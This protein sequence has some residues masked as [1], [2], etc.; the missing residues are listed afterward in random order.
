MLH[1]AEMPLKFWAEA[2]NTAVY[3]RNRSPTTALDGITPYECFHGE[4]PDVS[5][6]RVFG[7]KAFV[8]VPKERRSKLEGKSV[9]CIFVGYPSTSKGFKFYDIENDKMVIS[10]DAK[11]LENDFLH[12]DSKNSQNLPELS[13]VLIEE[14]HDVQNEELKNKVATRKSTRKRTIPE[15][16]GTITS[17]CWENE[18][19][20]CS[21]AIWIVLN[22]VVYMK[23]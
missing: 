23:Y 15:R 12:N 10:R 2:L 16:F 9:N 13:I 7:C 18:D 3:L 21:L 14:V 11:F 22:Q 17:D 8:H 20:D 6:L 4:K 19:N 1:H 5:N